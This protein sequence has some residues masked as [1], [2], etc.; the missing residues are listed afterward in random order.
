[1]LCNLVNPVTFETYLNL[2][3][4]KIVASQFCPITMVKEHV[5]DISV[6][7]SCSLGRTIWAELWHNKYAAGENM[8]EQ[9]YNS[10]F[11]RLRLSLKP[12]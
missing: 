1:M 6:D 3:I 2:F 4:L 5:N 7:C 12:N 9:V 11:L 10:I 8:V